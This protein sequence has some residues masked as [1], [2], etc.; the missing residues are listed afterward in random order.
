LECEEAYVENGMVELNLSASVDKPTA[1]VAYIKT[2]FNYKSGGGVRFFHNTNSIKI[3][4]DVPVPENLDLPCIVQYEAVVSSKSI[5]G[6]K[7]EKTVTCEVLIKNAKQPP[8][9]EEPEQPEHPMPGPT[10]EPVPVP[11]TTPIPEPTTTP[12]PEPTTT[13]IPEPTTTPIPEPTTTP[14]EPGNEDDEPEFIVTRKYIQGSWECW[15]EADRF[16]ALENIKICITAM[17]NVDRIVF[18]LS[19][20]LEAMTYTDS[21]GHTYDYAEDFFGT[22]IHFPGESTVRDWSSSWGGKL[23]SW[24][25]NLPLCDETVN[26]EGGRIRAPYRI[27]A[28]VCGKNGSVETVSMP[29]DITG[30]IYE[31]IHPQ[32]AD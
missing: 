30:N 17:G 12:I 1:E 6:D 7:L 8:S 21:D 32:P 19:P 31:M 9:S 26:W 16:L 24:S 23:F 11:T 13:P 28:N 14:T 3:T 4:H 2:L 22:Y 10:S 15:G 20:E 25:Y 27:E 18:R 5:F 29:L